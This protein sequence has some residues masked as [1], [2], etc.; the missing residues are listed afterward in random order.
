GAGGGGGGNGDPTGTETETESKTSSKTSSSRSLSSSSQSSSSSSSSS[1]APSC[2]FSAAPRR[3]RSRA[4]STKFQLRW[5]A[6]FGKRTSIATTQYHATCRDYAS[7]IESAV[8]GGTFALQADRTWP[9]EF[10]WSGGFY[11][12]P[13]ENKAQLF[14]AIFL[15]DTCSTQGGVVIIEFN[16]DTS[17]LNVKDV[18]TDVSTVNKFRGLQSR[19]GGAFTRWLR[20]QQPSDAAPP[21]PPADDGIG[22]DDNPADPPPRVAL[23]TTDQITTMK[24]TKGSLSPVS[25]TENQL[26]QAY[27]DLSTVDVVSGAGSFS[28]AQATLIADATNPAVGMPP[29][30]APFNQVV[31]ITNKAMGKLTFVNAEDLPKCLADLQPKLVAFIKSK[32]DSCNLPGNKKRADCRNPSTSA[33]A[34]QSHSASSVSSKSTSAPAKSTSSRASSSGMKSKPPTS[35]LAKSSSSQASSSG[36]K[37]KAASSSS[38]QL[39][40]SSAEPSPSSSKSNVTPS[41]T[42]PPTESKT[43]IPSGTTPS[44]PTN[45]CTGNQ[46]QG[47]CVA[48]TLPKMP[49]YSGPQPPSCY[50]ANGPGTPDPRINDA[51]AQ[52]AATDY[53]ASLASNKVVLTA[54][55][56]GP[57]PG[58]V[59]GAAENNGDLA[60]TVLYDAS[61]CPTDKST[62]TLDFTKFGAQSCFNNFYTTLAQFCGQD[63]TWGSYNPDYTLEGGIY[64]SD[65][66]L[67]SMAGQAGS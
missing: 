1:L 51:K 63:S 27:S 9:N 3:R 40:S 18:G 20:K 47:S 43:S 16:F 49:P 23:P 66:G 5:P 2:S 48:G 37:T 65:C 62:S 19:L 31:L 55:S 6:L 60:L 15:A 39:K 30:V 34:S 10:T 32:G 58:I 7:S 56:G 35:T 38:T 25:R 42:P 11:V 61:A 21:D 67:W 46:V 26:W 17:Q 44:S 53:C 59:K 14:G 45:T 52:Q 36:T 8:K 33:S 24:N 64:R 12:T 4:S 22:N 57:A 28:Q 54:D 41:P 50:K 29:L 13:D